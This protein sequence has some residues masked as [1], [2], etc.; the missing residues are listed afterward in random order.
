MCR[1]TSC[2][3]YHTYQIINFTN[4]FVSIQLKTN[5][6]LGRLEII[7]AREMAGNSHYFGLKAQYTPAYRSRWQVKKIATDRFEGVLSP[8]PIKLEG[9]DRNRWGLNVSSSF[10]FNNI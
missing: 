7:E 1:P 3:F 9:W 5:K 2:K 8:D 4:I 6:S 10:L